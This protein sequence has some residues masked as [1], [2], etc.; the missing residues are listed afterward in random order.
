MGKMTSLLEKY[1][2]IEKEESDSSLLDPSS[3]VEVSKE[4][5]VIEA[6]KESPTLEHVQHVESAKSHSQSTNQINNPISKDISAPSSKAEVSPE[7]SKTQEPPL[8]TFTSQSNSSAYTQLLTIEQIYEYLKL[9]H[10]ATTN[11]VFL[12]ENLIKALPEELPEFVKKTTVD[13]IIQASAMDLPKLLEDGHIRL[14]SIK[15]FCADY[16]R[17]NS[18]EIASLKSAIIADYHQQIKHRETL[19]SEETSLIQTEQNRIQ[20]IME[21]FNT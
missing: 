21:F 9:D 15:Q 14:D 6:P 20:S 5:E 1:K 7:V 3:A 13:N 10:L 8:E 4:Q 18:S 16:T 19:I 11:T 12:L 2:L 17:I